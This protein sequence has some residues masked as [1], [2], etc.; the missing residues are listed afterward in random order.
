MAKYHRPEN[1][2]APSR[3]PP[4]QTASAPVPTPPRKKPKAP[5]RVAGSAT[6]PVV[7]REKPAVVP[8]PAASVAAPPQSKMDV[9]N[10]GKTAFQYELQLSPTLGK[11]LQ[12]ATMTRAEATKRIWAYCK[13]KQLPHA[14][15]KYQL[16]EALSMALGRKTLEFKTLAKVIGGVALC[17]LG[18]PSEADDAPLGAPR[19]AVG[20]SQPS[21]AASDRLSPP[22]CRSTTSQ[23]RK[24]SSGRPTRATMAPLANAPSRS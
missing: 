13:E 15:G 6:K 3:Q 24:R 11:F 19:N 9:L 12:A 20:L 16:D 5:S 10:K 22:T 23:R 14:K 17:G 1:P 7:K 8:A 21:V 18:P 2:T 4:K